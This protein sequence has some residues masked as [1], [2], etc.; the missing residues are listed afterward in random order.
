MLQRDL[1]RQSARQG[2]AKNTEGPKRCLLNVV[3]FKFEI[4]AETKNAS[5]EVSPIFKPSVLSP[6]LQD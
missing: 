5:S 6:E 4:K 1:G 3:S 2:E